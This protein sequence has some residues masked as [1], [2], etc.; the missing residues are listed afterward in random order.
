MSYEPSGGSAAQKTNV[1]GILLLIGGILNVLL[2]LWMLING[3]SGMMN[4]Q[5]AVQQNL[6][7]MTPEQRRQNEKVEKDLGWSP[8]EVGAKIGGVTGVGWAVIALLGG[9]LGIMAGIKMRSLQ[10]YGLCMFGAIYTLIPCLSP[11]ACPCIFGMVAGI[12]RWLC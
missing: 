3:I 2:A 1:P 4:P 11:G 7:N 5:A 8:Q 6:Q 9:I 12:W 10:S